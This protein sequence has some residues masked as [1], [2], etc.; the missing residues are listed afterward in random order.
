M[1]L[2][3]TETICFEDPPCFSPAR[4]WLPTYA[5][6]GGMETCIWGELPTS[7]TGSQTS[8]LY[9]SP[10]GRMAQNTLTVN[11]VDVGSMLS[12]PTHIDIHIHQESALTQLLKAGSSL[13]ERLSH[14]PAKARIGY[15]Q[16]ALGAI[17]AGVGAIVHEKRRGKLSGCISGLLTLAGIAT[18]VAAVV[19]CVNSFIWQD[20]GF[21]D[22]SSVCDSLVPVTPTSW[23]QRRSSYS[24]WEEENCRRY[25]QMLMD[26]F[27]GIRALLLAICALQVIVSL[28]SLGVGLRSFCGQSSRALDEEGSE[29]NLLGENSVPPS[30]SKEKTTAVIVL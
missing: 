9:I 13:V 16:L 23:Y 7:K 28:A 10:A 17:A 19:F 6:L 26:L 2:P 12:Q 22:I 24:S 29:R 27:L 18:A 11:G 15:G 20:D 1:F 25:M 30:P 5:F 4:H 3:A 21:Y 8:L 14:R